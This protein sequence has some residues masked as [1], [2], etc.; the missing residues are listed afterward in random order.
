MEDSI[1]SWLQEYMRQESCKV[2]MHTPRDLTRVDTFFRYPDT[3]LE[4]LHRSHCLLPLG[5]KLSM[6]YMSQKAISA[7]YTKGSSIDER[8]CSAVRKMLNFLS[9]S[10]SVGGLPRIS[11]G[12]KHEV[13]VDSNARVHISVRV[14]L[15]N[16]PGL[17]L[18]YRLELLIFHERFKDLVDYER[19]TSSSTWRVL[20]DLSARTRDRNIQIRYVELSSV[21]I[22]RIATGK[23]MDGASFFNSTPQGGGVALMRHALLRLFRLLNI[24]AHWFV[25]K[26]KPE[27]QKKVAFYERPYILQISRFDPS[28]GIPDL[29]RAYKILRDRMSTEQVHFS[30]VP[31]LVLAGHGSVDDPDGTVVFNEIREL[32]SREEFSGIAND[33]IAVSL[34]KGKPI[35]C[36]A[37]G[38]IPHQ[39]IQH[40]N[41]I[42]VAVDG[43]SQGSQSVHNPMQAPLGRIDVVAHWMYRLLMDDELYA[44]YATAAAS[45]VHSYESFFTVCNAVNW[46]FVANGIM[47]GTLSQKLE[48]FSTEHG[49]ALAENDENAVSEAARAEIVEAAGPETSEQYFSRRRRLAGRARWAQELW[50]QQYKG[51]NWNDRDF[52]KM[53]EE[54]DF[55][56]RVVHKRAAYM[57]D[58]SGMPA[59]IV[60]LETNDAES[61][62]SVEDSSGSEDE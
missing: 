15:L 14:S 51:Y 30:K 16:V 25:M 38:G 9:P 59:N 33:V 2:R 32:L 1:V 34:I 17:M 8:S 13:E 27:T 29:I 43:Q 61:E 54:A 10:M 42:L 55:L 6:T 28:K 40:R 46:L 45:S 31:Q 12:Y 4:L 18:T 58:P 24:N 39:I 3:R 41:G 11:V 22:P 44:L 36:Y 7:L 49:V 20:Q 52:A 56:R 62:V 26:P 19:I 47:D 35:I 37:A 50:Q 60:Q 53:I 57:S 23:E 48:R 21:L 5:G